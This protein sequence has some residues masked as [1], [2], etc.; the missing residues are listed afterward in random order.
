MP[1]GIPRKKIF[2]IEQAVA[3]LPQEQAFPD[4][5]EADTDVLD[6]G[7]LTT[8]QKENNALTHALDA[9]KDDGL[10][11]EI[12]GDVFTMACGGRV[13]SGNINQPIQNIVRCAQQ[14]IGG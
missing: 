3:E 13:D 14:L 7:V 12:V 8:P 9:F 2:D 5:V 11:Y 4:V 6:V 1:R 10:K